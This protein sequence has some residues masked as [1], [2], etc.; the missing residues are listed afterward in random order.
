MNKIN[1][2]L[3]YNCKNYHNEIQKTTSTYDNVTLTT[4]S[5][6]L[7]SFFKY[8]KSFKLAF[9]DFDGNPPK[10]IDN[11]TTITFS[12]ETAFGNEPFIKQKIKDKTSYAIKK[13]CD[14]I[15]FLEKDREII[16]N[17]IVNVNT[18]ENDI[19]N[20]YK[21][22]EL[23]NEQIRNHNKEIDNIKKSLTRKIE[24]GDE[25]DEYSIHLERNHIHHINGLVHQ[26]TQFSIMWF[27]DKDTSAITDP[28]HVTINGT[29][30]IK[31]SYEIIMNDSPA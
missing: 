20:H 21:E 12:L 17:K 4:T 13:R 9:S 11:I 24:V 31:I 15:S 29:K 25:I 2:I 10:S 28:T 19:K 7:D 30:T 5:I 23:I 14:E 16:N 8:K 6:T 1:I 3:I 22:I 27:T 26:T 18:S